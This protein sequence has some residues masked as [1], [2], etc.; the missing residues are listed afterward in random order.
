MLNPSFQMSDSPCRLKHLHPT[1][2]LQYSEQ[3]S[4]STKDEIPCEWRWVLGLCFWAKKCK[5]LEA[6]RSRWTRLIPLY[7]GLDRHRQDRR[8]GG[9]GRSEENWCSSQFSQ[10]RRKME[11]GMYLSQYNSGRRLRRQA[12]SRAHVV[13]ICTY[14]ANKGRATIDFQ[15]LYRLCT[16]ATSILYP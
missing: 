14:G 1:L 5:S 12:Q 16:D 10:V 7:I 13:F 9:G 4:M 8:R 3:C 2:T 15:P 6:G 11:C